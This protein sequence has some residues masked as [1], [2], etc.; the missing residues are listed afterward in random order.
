MPIKVEVIAT[1]VIERPVT[2]GMMSVIE[3]A[4]YLTPGATTGRHGHATRRVC[5]TSAEK[6]STRVA[7][8]KSPGQ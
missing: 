5:I 3:R 4:G 8:A 7:G 6:P 1:V 2:A